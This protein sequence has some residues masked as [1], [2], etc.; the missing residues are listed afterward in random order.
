MT[1]NKYYAVRIGRKP[2]VY[3]TWDECRAQTDRYSGA[4]FK[5]FSTRVEAT[6]WVAGGGSDGTLSSTTPNGAAMRGKG[7]AARAPAAAAASRNPSSTAPVTTARDPPG[8]DWDRHRGPF[9]AVAVG[10]TPGIFTS[11]DGARASHEGFPGAKHRRFDTYADAETY[12][13][14]HGVEDIVVFPDG[15]G[16][17]GEEEEISGEQDEES[18]EDNSDE[19]S[20]DDDVSTACPTVTPPTPGSFMM[21]VYESTQR[22]LGTLTPPTTVG[23]SDNSIMA[24]PS[25]AQQEEEQQPPPSTMRPPPSSY[26]AHRADFAADDAASFDDEFGRYMSSQDI[27]PSS[28]AYRKLRTKAISHELKLHYSSPRSLLDD[29]EVKEE[30]EGEKNNDHVEEQHKPKPPPPRPQSAA[31]T[32]AAFRLD[33]YQ[34]M[35]RALRLPAYATERECTR[36]LREPLVNIVD[37]IDAARHKRPVQIWTDWEAFR[38]YTLRDDKRIDKEEAKADHGFLA[39]LLR[40]VSRKDGFEGGRRGR[41]RRRAD[42]DRQG[43]VKRAR[44]C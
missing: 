3:K 39:K 8:R 44:P 4:R 6:A 23:G 16:E 1:T 18:D 31:D 40:M 28:P 15:A 22:N 10:R 20:D 33:V 13:H 36:A 24:L 32:E 2:G 41:K 42:G 5:S 27:Q 19:E 25:S 26:F 9:Y 29:D 14:L 17:G 38:Q 30:E 7:N 43:S 21:S 11:Y 37:F 12:L 35:C 34:N